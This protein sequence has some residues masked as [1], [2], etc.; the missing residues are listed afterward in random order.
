M[1]LNINIHNKNSRSVEIQLK[2]LRENKV[3]IGLQKSLKSSL[4]SKGTIKDPNKTSSDIR[5]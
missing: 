5:L 1:Y 2:I 4:L 3:Y